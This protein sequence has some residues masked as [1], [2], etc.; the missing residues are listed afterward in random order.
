MPE[1]RPSRSPL[2]KRWAAPAIIAA[3]VAVVYAG[4]LLF[5]FVYD[6]NFQIVDNTWLTSARYIPRFFTSHV[7]AFAGISGVYWRPLF[8]LWFFLQ[9]SIFGVAPAGWHAAT[10]LMHGCATLLVYALARR[11]M[12]DRGAA[13]MAALIFGLHPALLES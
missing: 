11:L 2:D 12:A 9:R 8:L 6:D 5:G 10:V 13:L 1:T 7:W 4:T 3:A